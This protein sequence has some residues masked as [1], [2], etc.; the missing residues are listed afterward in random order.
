MNIPAGDHTIEFKFEPAV[1]QTGGTITMISAILIGLILLG[2][3][4]LKLKKRR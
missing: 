4:G 3:I 2:G 1:I